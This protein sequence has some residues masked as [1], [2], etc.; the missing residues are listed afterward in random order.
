MVQLDIPF[1]LYL[2]GSGE[3]ANRNIYQLAV[4]LDTEGQD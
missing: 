1:L 2:L 3:M 4:G